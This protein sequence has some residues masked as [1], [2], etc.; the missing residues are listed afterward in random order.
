MVSKPGRTSTF[1]CE[2]LSIPACFTLFRQLKVLEWVIVGKAYPTI[3]APAT[4]A[5][6]GYPFE[7]LVEAAESPFEKDS[8]IRL[9]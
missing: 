6:R 8:A 4:G 5:Y 7:V 9:D 1:Q 3:V 2:L